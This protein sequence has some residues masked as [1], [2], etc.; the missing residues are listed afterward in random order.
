[1][2]ASFGFYTILPFNPYK[3]GYLFPFDSLRDLVDLADKTKPVFW[4]RHFENDGQ[5]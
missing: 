5:V 4:F 2:T 3:S 1:M